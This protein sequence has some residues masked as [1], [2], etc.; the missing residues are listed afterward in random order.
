MTR[1]DT[2]IISVLINVG[3]L[4]LLFAT[5]MYGEPDKAKEP[6]PKVMAQESPFSPAPAELATAPM[7]APVE[8][9]TVAAPPEVQKEEEPA[10]V[11]AV[12]KGDTL[13][14]IARR[15]GVTIESLVRANGLRSPTLQMGQQLRIPLQLLPAVESEEVVEAAPPPRPVSAAPPA[16]KVAE[17]P[18]PATEYYTVKPGD[19]PWS[20]AKKNGVDLEALLRLNGLDDQKSRQIRPGDRLRIR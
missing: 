16:T 12:Q 7:A 3:L 10:M 5:A 18:K 6:E 9:A 17:P 4:T 15:Y 1:R 14:K 13:Q 2:I 8:P 19:N 20:I 11:V